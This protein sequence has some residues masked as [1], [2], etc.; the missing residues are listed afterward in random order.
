M[1][2]AI[3]RARGGSHVGVNTK[4]HERLMSLTNFRPIIITCITP[5][6]MNNPIG[7]GCCL[8]SI[9]K[10][11]S[12]LMYAAISMLVIWLINF[13]LPTR[14]SSFAAFKNPDNPNGTP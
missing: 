6:N 3:T 9:V 5:S 1:M 8:S 14:P 12:M 7:Q 10:F 2:I 11:L 13:L 4:S